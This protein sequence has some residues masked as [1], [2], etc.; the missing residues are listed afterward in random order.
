MKRNVEVKPEIRRAFEAKI[1]ES[2]NKCREKSGNVNIPDSG[3][4]S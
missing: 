2:I 4:L 3:N 1:V